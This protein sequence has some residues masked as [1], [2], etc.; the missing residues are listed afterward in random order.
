MFSSTTMESST[1]MPMQ[2][3]RA[4]VDT[5]FSVN[6]R[7]YIMKK[8]AMSE[9]GMA[10]RTMSEERHSRRKRRR[11]RAVTAMPSRRSRIVSESEDFDEGR[12]VGGDPQRHAAREEGGLCLRGP[13]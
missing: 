7:R 12:L 6:F 10:T 2:R 5:M 1:S 9:V 4:I 8:V 11:T 13:S 3:A